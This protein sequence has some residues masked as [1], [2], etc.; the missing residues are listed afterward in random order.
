[1]PGA[2]PDG[3]TPQTKGGFL[4]PNCPRHKFA[5]CSLKKKVN[6]EIGRLPVRSADFLGFLKQSHIAGRG[7][8]GEGELLLS[9]TGQ[10][11]HEHVH[12]QHQGRLSG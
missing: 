10:F 2:R 8:L 7:V 4:Q 1:M 3:E 9:R 12:V 6:L 11:H 5:I